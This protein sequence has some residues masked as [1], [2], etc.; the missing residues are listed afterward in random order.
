[1]EKLKVKHAHFTM[2]SGVQLV[3]FL[4]GETPLGLLWLHFRG[5]VLAFLSVNYHINVQMVFSGD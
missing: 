3:G 4:G 1:M 5:F 2:A